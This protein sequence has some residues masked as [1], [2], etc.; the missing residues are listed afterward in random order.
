MHRVE[1]QAV[2][3][4]RPSSAPIRERLE[5][6]RIVMYTV[7]VFDVLGNRLPG[8]QLGLDHCSLASGQSNYGSLQDMAS[9][10]RGDVAL[11]SRA[12]R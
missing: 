6:K 11:R 7:A 1:T 5:R 8:R 4:A 2:D 12:V 3:R 10:S 9:I